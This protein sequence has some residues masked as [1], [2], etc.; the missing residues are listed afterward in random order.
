MSFVQQ[1]VTTLE[2]TV[3]L[4]SL[5]LDEVVSLCLP[6]AHHLL[7]ILQLRFPQQVVLLLYFFPEDLAHFLEMYLTETADYYNSTTLL[8]EIPSFRTT[9]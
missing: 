4:R 1:L 8:Q 3:R 2:D 5:R 9:E 6:L 7:L